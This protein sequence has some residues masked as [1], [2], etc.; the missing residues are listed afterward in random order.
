MPKTVF[1]FYVDATNP[2]DAPAEAL[3]IFL[4]YCRSHGLA[5]EISA[6]LGFGWEAHGLLTQPKTAEK[7]A[8]LAQLRRTDTC[9][10]DTNF[11][12]M[13]H[14]GVFDFAQ[15]CIPS[16]A[17]HEG[18]WLYHRDVAV[19]TYQAYFEHIAAAGA[20]E[21]IRFSGVTFPGCSCAACVSGHKALQ[22]QGIC[23]P[24][25]AAWQA[26][27]N[28]AKMGH[29]RQHTL[30]CF[31]LGAEENPAA[32]LLLGE[33]VCGVYDLP[34]NARDCFGTWRNLPEDVNADYYISADGQSGRMV[35]LVR[36]GAAYCM[37]YT[38]WQGVNPLTG[39]GWPAFTQ[40]M[41]RVEK[42]LGDAIEWMRPSDYL[43]RVHNMFRA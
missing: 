5:G 11:E 36:A 28:L 39:I 42:Y 1:S 17:M 2:Y 14:A 27:L 23:D 18:I 16:G 10:L 37:F 43:E 21:G 26:L 8:F 35:E 20:L 19:D 13:T 31:I 7:E 30:P 29:F 34:P 22:A 40:V 38:H 41:K 33:E 24:S 15:Q 9:R 32:R 6:I 3:G 12:L 4:D 25:P